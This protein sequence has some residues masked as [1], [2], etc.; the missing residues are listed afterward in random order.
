MEAPTAKRLSAERAGAVRRSACA[1]PI[2]GAESCGDHSG[3]TA[4]VAPVGGAGGRLGGPSRSFSG[5]ARTLAGLPH[6]MGGRVW[7]WVG[8]PEDRRPAFH[9]RRLRCGHPAFSKDGRRPRARVELARVGGWRRRPRLGCL[10][11]GVV[12]CA[13]AS[14]WGRAF[15]GSLRGRG[16]VA[17]TL[18]SPR[19]VQPGAGGRMAPPS[20]P[21]CG[22]RITFPETKPGGCCRAG[23]GRRE[24]GGWRGHPNQGAWYGACP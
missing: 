13:S 7:N 18:P 10:A 22:S 12:A 5:G 11:R 20:P 23:A 15:T 8:A 2:C 6:Q 3:S 16:W 24:V 21:G 9:G 14:W 19:R 4:R 17:G 1:E